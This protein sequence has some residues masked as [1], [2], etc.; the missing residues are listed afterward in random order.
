[1]PALDPTSEPLVSFQDVSFRYKADSPEVLHGINLDV[2]AG[3]VIAILGHNGSGKTTT[4]KQALGLLKPTSGRVLLEGVETKKITVA[5]AARTVGYV[6]QSPT[7]ICN[8]HCP[9]HSPPQIPAGSFS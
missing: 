9:R 2:R 3:E 6:F 4:V 8:R 7:H 5:N 1:M